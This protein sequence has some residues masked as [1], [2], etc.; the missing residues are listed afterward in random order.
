MKEKTLDLT[1][2]EV[3]NTAWR[4]LSFLASSTFI[5]LMP[6]L[7][8]LA[9]MLENNFFSYDFFEKGVFGMKAFFWLL[10]LSLLAIS[11]VLFSPIFP[12]SEKLIK[13]KE[14]N[15]AIIISLLVSGCFWLIIFILIF[16]R[17]NSNWEILFY[18][19]AIGLFIVI[20][21]NSILHAKP[22]VQFMTLTLIII[23][24][25][26][27]TFNLRTSAAEMIGLALKAYGSGGNICITI[28]DTQ[29]SYNL[30]GRLILAAPDYLY[31]Q[32]NEHTSITS[33]RVDSNTI[34]ITGND[35][36]VTP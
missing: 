11:L 21:I 20:Q 22:P 24:T 35:E 33:I 7:L 34:Y 23:M 12:I 17:E 5:S 2:H 30:K 26:Y 32:R 14:N 9:Y 31:F 19:G 15:W 16:S 6:V 8:F 3:K 1:P 29:N 13:G 36:C 25:L 28:T 27:L 4:I 10:A 18:I